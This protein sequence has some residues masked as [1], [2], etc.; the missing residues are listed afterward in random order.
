MNKKSSQRTFHALLVGVVFGA[1]A[2]TAQAV[3]TYINNEKLVKNAF[4]QAA[5]TTGPGKYMG[6]HLMVTPG[7]AYYRNEGLIWFHDEESR[8]VNKCEYNA[9]T[10][11]LFG[12]PLQTI[13]QVECRPID[14]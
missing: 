3:T 8:T 1:A 11:H 13:R 14:P 2:T 6:G 9:Y 4:D 12:M 5:Q 7:L 10:Y